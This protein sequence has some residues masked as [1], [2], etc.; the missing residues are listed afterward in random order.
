MLRRPFCAAHIN[1]AICRQR[2]F[3]GACLFGKSRDICHAQYCLYQH[4]YCGPSRKYC[5]AVVVYSTWH[6]RHGKSLNPIHTPDTAIQARWNSFVDRNWPASTADGYGG[7]MRWHGSALAQITD[8]HRVRQALK[9]DWVCLDFRP[10]RTGGFLY[11]N[12][13]QAVALDYE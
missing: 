10:I 2:K 4:Q 1:F 9:Q 11:V 12:Q 7:V 5:S 6:P 13:S 3:A 8:L